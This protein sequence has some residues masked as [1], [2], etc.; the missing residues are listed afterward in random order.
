MCFK[1][2]HCERELL[3]RC[4]PL[5]RTLNW[6]PDEDC[7]PT[8]RRG[9]RTV[10]FSYFSMLLIMNH[11]SSR[12][13]LCIAILGAAL[14]M[15]LSSGWGQVNTPPDGFGILPDEVGVHYGPANSVAITVAGA[16]LL[17][18]APDGEFVTAATGQVLWALRH[19][20]TSSSIPAPGPLDEVDLHRRDSAGQWI[21]ETTLQAPLAAGGTSEFGAS[22]VASGNRLFIGAPGAV[23]SSS[24]AGGVVYVYE[25]DGTTLTSVQ[26][27]EL[28][29]GVA[30]D[31]FG[32]ALAVEGG[33]LL[34]GAPG[35]DKVDGGSTVADAGAVYFHELSGTW[36]LVRTAWSSQPQAGAQFGFSVG[37]SGRRFA[38]GAP[39]EDGEYVVG[40]TPTV[41]SDAGAV[42]LGRWDAPAGLLAYKNLFSTYAP[43]QA[44]MS[45]LTGSHFGWS[46]AVDDH[47]RVAVSMP[48]SSW[49][50]MDNMTG[51][52]SGLVMVMHWN[53][54]MSP[55]E[56]FVRTSFSHAELPAGA[57]F[58]EHVESA[59]G[60]VDF[61]IRTGQRVNNAPVHYYALEAIQRSQVPWWAAWRRL[62][63]WVIWWQRMPRMRP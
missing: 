13:S 42:Y 28:A 54:E 52:D 18:A 53:G 30:G 35:R 24:V 46:V 51:W 23:N 22:V 8:L 26:T 36:S 7:F 17:D 1:P 63:G 49:T 50:S 48:D 37:L 11:L 44:T 39:Y 32:A 41:L 15:P 61:G 27:L 34:V 55:D 62:A 14:S 20:P 21:Y 10:L 47:M 43:V 60:N 45:G 16:N 6:P 5:G 4:L 38:V 2:L 56:A 12:I 58:G 31:R 19:T 29:D 57:R 40:S 59:A 25:F 9:S 33:R 3:P